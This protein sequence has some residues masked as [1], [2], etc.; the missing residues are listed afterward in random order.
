MP[1]GEKWR[2]FLDDHYEVSNL[3]RV[4][5][6]KARKGAVVG[7]EIRQFPDRGY[8]HVVVSVNATLQTLWVHKLVTDAFLGQRPAGMNV[9]HKDG[10]KANNVL[11]NLEYVTFSRNTRHAI[12]AGLIR[13]Q[14]D[15]GRFINAMR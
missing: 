14:A 6:L 11:S 10:N 15:T 5:R 9:N 7:R 12:E 1:R 8:M 13:R 4:R 3:G 2:S